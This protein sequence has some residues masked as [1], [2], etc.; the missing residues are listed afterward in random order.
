MALSRKWGSALL[1]GVVLLAALGAPSAKGDG[2]YGPDYRFCGAFNADYRI[3]VYESHM[4]C[5]MAMRVQKEY[6]LGPDERRVVVNGGSGAAGYVLLKRF[7]GWKCTSGSGGGAC[8]KGRKVAAYQNRAIIGR[9]AGGG[10][11][12]C[13]D[14]VIRNSDGGVYTRTRGLFQKNASCRLARKLARRYLAN[15]G[16]RP[17][18]TL[19]FIC[20]GGSDGVACSNGEKRVTWGY[21]Y[22]RPALDTSG[23]ASSAARARAAAT[24]R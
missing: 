20:D 11:N 3:Q 21:Y 15:D 16:I 18:R 12:R 22:D 19:G 10:Y 2:P 4:S 23:V 14:V 13:R 5:R 24:P 9:G 1:V 7:P 8:R 6:W 17:P